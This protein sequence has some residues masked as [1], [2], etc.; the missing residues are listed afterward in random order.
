MSQG[1]Q[2]VLTDDRACMQCGYNLKGLPLSGNCP[3][4]ARAVEDSLRGVFLQYASD[5]YLKTTL[6]GLS[7]V[8]NGILVMIVVN[9]AGAVTSSAFA[10]S[11]VELVMSA[12]GMVPSVMLVLGYWRYTAPDP[13]FT[14][15]E[16]PNA[17][18]KV[19]RIAVCVQAGGT[20]F[21]FLS[22]LL[23]LTVVGNQPTAGSSIAS[24][25]FGVTMLV[26][27]V[28]LAAWLVQFFATMR[29][30]RWMASRV[31]DALIIRRTKTYMWLLPVIGAVGLFVLIGPLIAL[32]L[33][34]NLH[35]RLRK[36]L[37]SIIATG[38]PATLKGMVG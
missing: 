10:S 11:G 17:A 20:F 13:Q 6:S 8:L 26:G 34:W 3:E 18:R 27:I 22:G 25:L 36:H 35:D 4:C 29:Y 5:R 37:K 33:Y 21:M 16:P 38:Q 9:V 19:M 31:P 30:T 28:G 24:L 7:L 14:G 15:Q 12:I 1:P 32:V 2:P 23:T